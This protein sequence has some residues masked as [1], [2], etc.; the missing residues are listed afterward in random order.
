MLGL[1]ARMALLGARFDLGPRFGELAQALVAPRQFVGNR[2]AIGN[3]GCVGRLGFSHQ[4]GDFSLQL[5]L[6]L[7]RMLIG[8]RAMP[9][10]VGMNLCAVEPNRSQLE[11]AH[12]ARQQQDLNKQRLDLL[13]EP[14]PET[15]NRV[16]VGMIVCRNETER[17]RVIGRPLQ[18]AARKH[19]RRVA[20]NQDAQQHSGMM[21]SRTGAAIG[22]DHG[23]QVETVDH[24]RHE[25]RQMFFWQPF[26]HRRGKQ[27]SRLPFK[28]AKVVHRKRPGESENQHADSSLS[29]GVR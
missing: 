15:R 23:V 22:A 8:K 10:G 27:K 3:V 20:V 6:D 16:V 5:S 1:L 4:I 25:A 13:E 29:R 18:L 26:V 28:I 19:A 2:P 7:A 21:R 17:H 24:L 14:P 11:D 12:L 9:A